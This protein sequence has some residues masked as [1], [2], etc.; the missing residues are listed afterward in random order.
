MAVTVA[1]FR[2]R[3]PEFLGVDDAYV[4]VHLDDAETHI[5]RT[6]WDANPLRLQGDQGQAYR[7]AHTMALSPMGLGAKLV[8][9]K[10]TAGLGATTYGIQ[11]TDMAKTLSMGFRIAYPLSP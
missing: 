9:A 3:F 1:Q 2:A 5:D 8:A 7:A 6:I 10:D 11:Y 4:Q